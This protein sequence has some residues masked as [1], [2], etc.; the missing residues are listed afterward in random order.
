MAKTTSDS[1]LGVIRKF[2]LVLTRRAV[3]MLVCEQIRDPAA[4]MPNM[5]MPSGERHGVGRGLRSLTALVVYNLILLSLQPTTAS[6]Q[7]EN[8]T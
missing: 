8:D 5:V 2:E 1:I 7:D 6:T 3:N 4:N